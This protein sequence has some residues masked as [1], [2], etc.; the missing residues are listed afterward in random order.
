M[1]FTICIATTLVAAV[2]ALLLSGCGKDAAQTAPQ[3]LAEETA[4]A[5]LEEAFASSTGELKEHADEA[6]RSLR[7][8]D[9]PMALV[10]LQTLTERTDLTS[11]QRALTS[12][13]I[14]TAN[15][16]VAEAAAA[17]DA[18]AKKL[19]RYREFTK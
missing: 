7:V 18:E 13:A 5:T 1:K 9:Y 16:K 15:K 19:Q 14:L 6:V 4:P 10:V 11:S 8:E 17:G 2:G 3:A 12:Q